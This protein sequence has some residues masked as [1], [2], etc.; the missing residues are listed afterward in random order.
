MVQV[1]RDLLPPS[2]SSR[3]ARVGRIALGRHKDPAASGSC[4]PPPPPIHR[5]NV[6]LTMQ[7][8]SQISTGQ[9]SAPCRLP[10]SR[11]PCTGLEAI[12]TMIKASESASRP[13]RS[14]YQAATQANQRNSTTSMRHH[15]YRHG[16]SY[17]NHTPQCPNLRSLRHPSKHTA[18]GTQMHTLTLTGRVQLP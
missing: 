15:H 16:A 3:T 12:L 6:S 18:T 11:H 17:Q 4:E 1:H 8:T 5:P 13:Y 7:I 10:T 9:S 14:L 2:L